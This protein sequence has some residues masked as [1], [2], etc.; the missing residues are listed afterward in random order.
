MLSVRATLTK[1]GNGRGILLPKEMCDA[2]SLSVGDSVS[3]V[4]DEASRTVTLE[5]PD[6]YMLSALM[7][8]YDGSKPAEIDAPGES[9][10]GELW[11]RS[12]AIS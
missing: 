6:A 8:G 2:L 10:G 12:N 3:L 5:N 4:L 9:V 1:W 11:R 7:A